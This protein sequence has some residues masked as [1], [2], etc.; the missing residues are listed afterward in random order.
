MIRVGRLLLLL[1]A[2]PVTSACSRSARRRRRWPARS[3]WPSSTR[4]SGPVIRSG[5]PP[6]PSPF[7]AIGSPAWAAQT[8]SESSSPQPGPPAGRWRSSTPAGSSWS[9]ASSTRTCTSSTAASAWPR[10][11]CATPGRAT[12][13]VARIAAFAKT[14]PAGTW[15][16]GGDWDHQLWGGELPRRE[17]ID[18][19]TPD[20]PVWVNRLDGHMALANS[21]AL[22]AAGVTRA[23]Q[24]VSGG[25][26]V[27][28]A[29]GEPTGLLKDNAMELVAAKMPPPTAE[30]Q[31]RALDAAMRYVAEQGVTSVHHMGTWNELEVF[32]R[33][34]KAGRL[35]D[36]HL[37]RGAA[38]HLAA[39]GG[40]REGAHLWAG[41]PR[42]RLAAHRRAEGLRRRL[43]RLAH[44]R[45]R[46][47]VH[48][49]A[50]GPRLLRQHTGGSL[51]LDQ[52]RRCR[53]PAGGRARDWRSRQHHAARH[54]RARRPTLTAFAIAD[55]ASSTRS[56]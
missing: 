41:G 16:T 38:R 29:R 30:M 14:V 32:T 18:A 36:A 9:P 45:V 42:R 24:D 5:L 1:L 34:R 43:A 20:H 47:A 13:F 33:A 7:P 53:R 48:R 35:T 15:I 27:R 22:Q 40:H 46:G 12:E 55:S 31:D 6:K 52:R 37:R 4:K 26:I 56:T 39:A 49:R 8:R 28:D 51:R 54:L 19:A 21:A 25:E 44:R 2:L 50:E 10:C 23:M 11:S 17:W 3:R